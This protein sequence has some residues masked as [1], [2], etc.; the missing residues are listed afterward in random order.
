M[1]LTT[2][3]EKFVQSLAKG[4]NQYESYLI[5]Y[6]SSKSWKRNSVDCEASKLFKQDKVKQRYETLMERIRERETKKTMWSR[7][8]SIETLK[9]VIDVNKQDLERIQDAMEEELEIIYKEI[10]EKPEEAERLIREAIKQR[11]SRRTTQTNN[12]GITDAVSELNKMQGYNEET[13]NMNGV[14]IFAGEDELED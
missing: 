1:K 9:Y 2:Q 3:Q 13:I 11:K 6:P 8:E 5:A 4:K 10:K 7:E 14:V 12:K